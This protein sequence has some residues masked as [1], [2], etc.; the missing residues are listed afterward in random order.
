ML[1]RC[2]YSNQAVKRALEDRTAA[3]NEKTEALQERTVAL[4]E[5]TAALDELKI[6]RP[7]RTA[8]GLSPGD[9]PGRS[10]IDRGE[11]QRR[12]A[13]TREHRPAETRMGVAIFVPAVPTPS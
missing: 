1:P 4:G 5:R 11:R 6:T 2:L 10:R 9:R 13:R 3:L 7:A 8:D 12:G